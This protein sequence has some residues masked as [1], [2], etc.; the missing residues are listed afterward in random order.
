VNFAHR[1][2]IKKVRAFYATAEVKLAAASRFCGMVREAADRALTRLGSRVVV[3]GRCCR[4]GCGKAGF[5]GVITREGPDEEYGV[6]LFTGD[7]IR[8][9]PRGFTVL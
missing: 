4:D 3:N 6:R 5:T 9:C 7:L 1:W 2:A 8:L